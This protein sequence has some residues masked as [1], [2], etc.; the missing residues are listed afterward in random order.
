M[1]CFFM[2][3]VGHVNHGERTNPLEFGGK[4]S[5]VKVTM[6]K[7]G[8]RRYAMLCV[9]LYLHSSKKSNVIRR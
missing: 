6:G 4:K 3:L 2:K 7:C 5:K 8:V 1:V 9:V